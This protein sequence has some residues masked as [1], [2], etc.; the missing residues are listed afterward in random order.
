MKH[1][2]IWYVVA[3]GGR[4][5]ILRKRPAEEG[6]ASRHPM[7][8]I[9]SAFDA[10]DI[11]LRTHDLGAD[12][13][14]RSHESQGGVRHALAPRT[15]LHLA[16]KQSFVRELARLLNE[17]NAAEAFDR[18]ALVAPPTAL[19]SLT[20][21]L[22]AAVLLKIGGTLP[23]DLTHTPEAELAAHLADLTVVG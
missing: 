4:A 15:D 20:D 3:D 2:R 22:D 13:P 1:P 8:E 10:A 23:K 21:A 12:R 17:A 5:R 7:F 14:G 19:K 9:L 16:D 11:H 18:L 6:G